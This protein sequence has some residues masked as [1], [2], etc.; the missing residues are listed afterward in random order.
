MLTALGIFDDPKYRNHLPVTHV[1]EDR[2]WRT[3]TVMPMGGRI[4]FERLHCETSIEGEG[5]FV[6]I[7]INDDIVPL[8]KCHDGP[9]GSCS[10]DRFVK[11]V[12]KRKGQVGTFHDVCETK[13]QETTGLTFLRQS[14]YRSVED[15][16]ILP[17]GIEKT[18]ETHQKVLKLDD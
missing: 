1:A 8:P 7:N 11:M 16:R 3:S 13:E 5:L 9:G 14:A 12:H 15:L 10:L 2:V 18:G 6:R 17:S 4:T